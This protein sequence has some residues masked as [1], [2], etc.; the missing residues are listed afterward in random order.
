MNICIGGDLDGQV[1]HFDAIRFNAKD[2]D[3]TKTSEYYKQKYVI[4]ED[5]FCFWL[6][7]GVDLG[8]ATEKVEL[9]LRKPKQ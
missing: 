6:P 9:L 7:V 1:F 5:L 4:G 2:I 3:E 8:Q